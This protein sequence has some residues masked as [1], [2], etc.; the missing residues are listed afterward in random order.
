M[1]CKASSIRDCHRLGKYSTTNSPSRPLLVSLNSTV[2]VHDVL[3]RRQCLS[4]TIFI[5]PDLSPSARK[6]ESFLLQERRNLL[7][8][9]FRSRPYRSIKMRG[10]N[11][12]VYGQLYGSVLTPP[13][14]AFVLSTVDSAPHYQLLHNKKIK[15]PCGHLRPYS[16]QWLYRSGAIASDHP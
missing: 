8:Q 15:G 16:R 9:K 12:Y 1:E 10:S 3:F 13:E 2:D 7:I 5:K 4:S 14:S 6:A 11:I